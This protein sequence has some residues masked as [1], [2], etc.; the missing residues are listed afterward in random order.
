MFAAFG[1]EAMG[2]VVGD[3]YFVDPMP[4]PRS[5]NPRAGSQIGTTA[6]R[7]G[8]AAGIDLRGRPNRF[9]PPGVAGG[10]FRSPSAHRE[11]G[12]AHHHP[13][14]NGWEP[15]RRNFVPELSADPLSW[16]AGE[17]A[18]PDTV[19]ARAGVDA[20]EVSDADKAGLA[21]AGPEIVATVKRMLDGVRSGELAP[22]PAE[23]VAA[24]RTGWL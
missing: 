6:G 21:A 22:A 2:V 1:F 17:L 14:F 9:H 16:L 8:R 3:M 24:A 7:P 11:A 18:D 4:N 5:G 12:P 23:L 15:G 19:L 10:P 13:R 20:D